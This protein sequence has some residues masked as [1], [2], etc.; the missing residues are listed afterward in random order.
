MEVAAHGEITGLE[1]PCLLIAAKDD[2]EPDASCIQSS[3][4]V[5]IIYFF[6]WIYHHP[7]ACNRVPN[8][9]FVAQINQIYTKIV[10][11]VENITFDF[12]CDQ[13]LVCIG[14]CR[15]RSIF[16]SS[17]TRVFIL[18]F[19]RSVYLFTCYY[20]SLLDC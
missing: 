6:L 8:I 18:I 7:V 1:V 13:V 17:T 2:L 10:T 3:A 12:C 5:W 16:D 11:P 4:R 20:S 14:I 19:F 15:S 9:L